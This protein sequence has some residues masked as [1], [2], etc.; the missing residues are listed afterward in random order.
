MWVG[1]QRERL[2]FFLPRLRADG[3]GW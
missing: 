2:A 1:V 3:K